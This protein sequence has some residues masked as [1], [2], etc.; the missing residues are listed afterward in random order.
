MSALLGLKSLYLGMSS[1]SKGRAGVPHFS[2]HCRLLSVTTEIALQPV[3][4]RHMVLVF[5]Q[6]KRQHGMGG[7]L[8]LCVD[9]VHAACHGKIRP[10]EP[11]RCCTKAVF[12]A[13]AGT[14][15]CL[16][17]SFCSIFSPFVVRPFLLGSRSALHP[18][19]LSFPCC[20]LVEHHVPDRKMQS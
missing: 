14:Y 6:D 13:S 7:R 4:R 3:R 10:L 15:S 2:L 18:I 5:T 19:P 8:N 17:S 12:P 11:V 1:C 9:G 20:P 16:Y